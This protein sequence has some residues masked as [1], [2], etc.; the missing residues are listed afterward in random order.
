MAQQYEIPSHC[1]TAVIFKETIMFV[2]EPIVVPFYYSCIKSDA[3][4]FFLKYCLDCSLRD[5]T[6]RRAGA[7]NNGCRLSRK[8]KSEDVVESLQMPIP[9][10]FMVLYSNGNRPLFGYDTVDCI[11]PLRLGNIGRYGDWCN[12]DVAYNNKSPSSVYNGYM[13]SIHNR[14]LT[15]QDST[16]YPQYLKAVAQDFTKIQA[17]SVIDPKYWGDMLNVVEKPRSIIWSSSPD[18]DYY[19][20]GA[21][22]YVKIQ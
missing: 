15:N 21:N 2:F 12:G 17:D 3:E 14:D 4:D 13:Q 8:V 9:R 20:Q 18:T 1:E 5:K 7:I 22:Y 19:Q 11:K 6:C 10:H 16:T